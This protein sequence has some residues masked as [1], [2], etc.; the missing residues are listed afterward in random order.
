MGI[1]PVTLRVSTVGDELKMATGG[2]SRVWGLALKDRAA[3]LMAGRLADGALWFDDENGA[4]ISSRFYLPEGGVSA[5]DSPG[6]PFS[7]PNADAEL[8]RALEATIRQTGARRLIRMPE[9]MNDPRFAA[10]IAA[11]FRRLFGNRLGR[12]RARG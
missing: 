3:V 1:S 9:H 4:W 7:D 5:L 2:R 10:E 11:E 6:R 12:R 8:F